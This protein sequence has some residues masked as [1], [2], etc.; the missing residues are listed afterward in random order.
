MHG[1][2]PVD[3]PLLRLRRRLC[4]GFVCMA[5]APQSPS[6][7]KGLMAYGMGHEATMATGLSIPVSSL[8]RFFRSLSLLV[9][10]LVLSSRSS[11][12]APS[13][14]LHDLFL[15]SFGPRYL[16]HLTR[17]SPVSPSLSIALALFCLLESA[18]A[19]TQV[20]ASPSFV[21]TLLSCQ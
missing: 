14:H 12:S 3:S 17:A 19:P 8:L 4:H 11:P 21:S 2:C 20:C 9:L 10:L 13:S 15:L 16:G 18:A 6:R 5:F 7:I 1:Q